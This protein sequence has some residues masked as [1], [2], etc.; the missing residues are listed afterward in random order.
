MKPQALA[1]YEYMRLRG[2]FVTSAEIVRDCLTT[3]PSKRLDE[4][5]DAGMII[6][7]K[8]IGRQMEY[9]ALEGRAA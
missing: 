4:L 3:T 5:H 8:K 7:R 1:I 2:G 9:C 6:K